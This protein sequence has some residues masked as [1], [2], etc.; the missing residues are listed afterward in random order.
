MQPTSIDPGRKTVLVMFAGAVLAAC[1]PSEPPAPPPL[2]ISVVE[3]VQRDADIT[4]D[5][6]GQTRGSTDIPIR[7]RVQGFLESIEFSEGRPVEKGQLLYTIDPA[8]FRAKVVEAEGRVAEARTMLANAKADLDR[9]RPLAEMKAVSQQDLDGAVAR[10]EASIG[11]LQAAN[12]QLDQA[13]IELSYTRLLSPIDGSI[14]ISAAKVGE[15][16]GAEPNPVVLNFVS[17]NDPI[18]VRFSINERDYLRL[19]RLFVERHEA[20]GDDAAEDDRADLTLILADGSVHPYKGRI[21]AYDAAINPTTGT[22]TMEAD[23][24]NPTGIVLAGQ[25]ARVRGVIE[26]RRD[27]VLVPLRAIAELQGIFRVFVVG[28]DG[29]VQLRVVELGPSIGNLRIIEEG[30][31]AG[32]RVAVEGLL[33]LQNGSTVNPKVV[34]LA[35]LEPDDEGEGS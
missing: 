15:F 35:S 12:A 25:F 14:G 24:D 23:F 13:E 26:R 3:A 8:P 10:Y 6:V 27:A 20:F 31:Q 1:G 34:D 2:D 32:E 11:N 33:R 30:L 9:I 19:A 17:R 29:T 28:E 22:F 16:V 5:L 4:L 18:R 21:I 7:A